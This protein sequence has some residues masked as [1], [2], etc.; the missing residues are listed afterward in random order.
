MRLKLADAGW[1]ESRAQGELAH[2][3]QALGIADDWSREHERGRGSK[4]LD[5]LFASPT[6]ETRVAVELMLGGIDADH[7]TRLL[8]YA[9]R[10]RSGCADVRAVLIAEDCAGKYGRLANCLARAGL[11]EI[12]LMHVE[13]H[14]EGDILA[15]ETHHPGAAP[16]AVVEKDLE[17]VWLAKPDFHLVAALLERIVEADPVWR[18]TY[19]THIGGRRIEPTFNCVAFHGGTNGVYTVEIKL[20]RAAEHDRAVRAISE[21]WSYRK[22][23]QVRLEHYRIQFDKTWDKDRLRLL[24]DLL[25]QAN[26]R[27][28]NKGIAR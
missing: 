3:A 1:S 25:V 14:L 20:P 18:P 8:E 26:E 7:V 24:G 27:W 23:N 9:E 13:R 15:I 17:E 5:I 2:N 10:E 12:Y 11:I 16:Q 28:R 4:R 19:R 22:Q 21:N 6:G